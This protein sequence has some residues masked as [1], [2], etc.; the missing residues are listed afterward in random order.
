MDLVYTNVADRLTDLTLSILFEERGE[1]VAV[2]PCTESKVVY[3]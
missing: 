1:E 2:G 3:T